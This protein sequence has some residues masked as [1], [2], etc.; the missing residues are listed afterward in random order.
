MLRAI[1]P[2]SAVVDRPDKFWQFGRADA[3]HMAHARLWLEQISQGCGRILIGPTVRDGEAIDLADVLLE[4]AAD[5]KRT[6][7]LDRADHREH[8]AAGDG[9]DV[10]CA[11]QPECVALE[12]GEKPRGMARIKSRQPVGRGGLRK[13]D[14]G[15]SGL[16]A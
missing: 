8:F 4:A 7:R 15:L 1:I 6:A 5:I 13:P 3:G 9:P 2:E 16:P 12:A 10:L 14:S 11:E